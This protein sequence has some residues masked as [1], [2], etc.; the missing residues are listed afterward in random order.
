GLPNAGKSTLFNALLGRRR[1]ITSAMA[2]TTRD[3]LCEMMTLRGSAGRRV[4]VELVDIA[5][6]DGG[7]D[8]SVESRGEIDLAMRHAAA[9]E[10]RNGSVILWCDERGVFDGAAIGVTLDASRVIR[11]RTKRDRPGG[12]LGDV[13]V[14]AIGTE[15]DGLGALRGAV[16]EAVWGSRAVVTGMDLLP[17][18]AGALVRCRDAL[19][20]VTRMIDVAGGSLRDETLAE[21]LASA[22]E[23]IGELTGRVERDDVLGLIFSTFCIGK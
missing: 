16:F 3:A 4:D 19:S 17:R 12:T 21:E 18:N 8:A 11:V 2:G 9:A 22:G 20:E 1:A 10:I 23:A 7:G 6:L 5:G 14:S 13:A 15:G